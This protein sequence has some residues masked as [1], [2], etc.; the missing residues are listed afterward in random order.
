MDQIE[1][2]HRIEEIQIEQSEL[3][4]ERMGLKYQLKL[5]KEKSYG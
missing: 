3:E 1:L 4:K 5:L 2:E